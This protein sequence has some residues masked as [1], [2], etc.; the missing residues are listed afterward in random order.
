MR[1]KTAVS[2]AHVQRCERQSA[3]GERRGGFDYL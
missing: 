1:E 2:E 3:A